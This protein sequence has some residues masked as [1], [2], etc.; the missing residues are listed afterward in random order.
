MIGNYIYLIIKPIVDYLWKMKYYKLPLYACLDPAGDVDG[1]DDTESLALDL[2]GALR[3]PGDVEGLDDIE[4]L[5]G[6]TGTAAF[7]ED[8]LK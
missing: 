2:T 4:D 8:F 3:L 5:T 1:L 7:D 6:V